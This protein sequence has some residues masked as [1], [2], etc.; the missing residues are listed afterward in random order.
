MTLDFDL[1]QIDEPKYFFAFVYPF[2]RPEINLHDLT[3]ESRWNGMSRNYFFDGNN[4]LLF[5]IGGAFVN[6]QLRFASLYLQLSLS[7]G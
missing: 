7:F 1:A 5:K 3:S 6:L 4:V 2:T